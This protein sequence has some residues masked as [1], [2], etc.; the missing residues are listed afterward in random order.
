MSA[1]RGGKGTYR[2][3]DDLDTDALRHDPKP[4]V[5]LHGPFPDAGDEGCGPCYATSGG[6]GVAWW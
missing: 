3:V 5:G 6:T 1:A 2:I 4:V